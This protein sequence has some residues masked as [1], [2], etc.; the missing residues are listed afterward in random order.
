MAKV[1][2]PRRLVPNLRLGMHIWGLLPPIQAISA[3]NIVKLKSKLQ[4][5]KPI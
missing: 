1:C 3:Y 4:N 5:R 2:L